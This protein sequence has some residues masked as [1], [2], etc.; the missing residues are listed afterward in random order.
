METRQHK[1]ALPPAAAPV[2][3]RP[4]ISAQ[5]Q[6]FDYLR[7]ALVFKNLVMANRVRSSFLGNSYSD[8]RL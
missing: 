4:R 1:T 8:C 6:K 5:K 7:T 3:K 2:P